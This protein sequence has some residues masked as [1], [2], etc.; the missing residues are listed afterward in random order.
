MNISKKNQDLKC[1]PRY[2][3]EHFDFRDKITRLKMNLFSAK[4]EEKEVILDKIKKLSVEHE[5]FLKEYQN[6]RDIHTTYA[7]D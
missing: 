7:N 3:E 6:E 1:P 2:T 4:S 5:K